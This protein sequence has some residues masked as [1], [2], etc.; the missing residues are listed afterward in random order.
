MASPTNTTARTPEATAS[1]RASDSTLPIWVLPP[2]QSILP[3]SLASC[4]LSEIQPRG[5]AF[6]EAAII[7]QADVETAERRRLA[8]HVGLQRAGHVPGR[9]PAHGGV[10]REHQPASRA[11]PHAA[12]SRAPWRRRRRYRPM[13]TASASGSE[14][15]CRC[16]VLRRWTRRS[17]ISVWS[18]RRTSA[19]ADCS[20]LMWAE[21]AAF[22]A[23]VD[24]LTGSRC[25]DLS[26]SRAERRCQLLGSAHR[27]ATGPGIGQIVGGS[28]SSTGASVAVVVVE[29]FVEHALDRGLCLVRTGV[30]HVVVLEAGL[31][32]RDA[33]LL[34]LLGIGNRRRDR[35]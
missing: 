11:R 18:V 6:V 19:L 23:R 7:D 21:I 10:E 29:E 34:A 28:W 9:L 16:A 14:P 25:G 26:S 17:Q 8:K 35:S 30:A 2:R 12:T 4:A 27:G 20:E 24:A 1:R 32:D 15:T 33:G 13:R 5:A 22:N 31:H 3:I